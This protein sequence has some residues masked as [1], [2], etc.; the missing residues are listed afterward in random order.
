VRSLEDVTEFD[1][2][3]RLEVVDIARRLALSKPH[4]FRQFM[5]GKEIFCQGNFDCLSHTKMVESAFVKAVE[6][7]VEE[8][9]QKYKDCSHDWLHVERVRNMAL[10]LASGEPG[11]DTEIIQLGALL[12]DVGDF[13]FIKNGDTTASTITNLLI[14]NG[15]PQNKIDAVL[16]IVDN[17]SYRHELEHGCSPDR[18]ICWKEFCCIQDAD[19][20]DAIGAIG[21]ARC[22]AYSGKRNIPLCIPGHKASSEMTAEEY[23]EQ[24]KNGGGSARCHFEE[25]LLKLKD[26]MKSEAGKKEAVRRHEFMLS[27][28]KNFDQDCGP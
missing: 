15:Y 16:Q 5:I 10:K 8:Y 22:L 24:T 14:L 27:F 7:F 18:I 21:V 28:M 19:R 4:T 11:L 13:K 25:K 20:L 3:S 2:S 6:V 12:H 23:N 26:L 17:I 9:M 1:N